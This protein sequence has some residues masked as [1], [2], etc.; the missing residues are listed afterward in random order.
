M[1]LLCFVVIIVFAGVFVH[2]PFT[3]IRTDNFYKESPGLASLLN[4]PHG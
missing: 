2:V 3:L 4:G 1:Y